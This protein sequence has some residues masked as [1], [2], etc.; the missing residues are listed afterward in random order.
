MKLGLFIL[1]IISIFIP[2]LVI[3]LPVP[4]FIVQSS[5]LIY[6]LYYTS[7]IILI[8]IALYVCYFHWYS[9]LK[10]KDKS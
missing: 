2:E 3:G 6:C 7:K 8:V 10:K 4:S 9:N 1:V 5:E